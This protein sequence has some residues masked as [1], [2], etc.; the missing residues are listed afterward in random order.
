[1]ATVFR[2]IWGKEA[3]IPQTATKGSLYITTDTGKIFLDT[4]DDISGRIDLN[5]QNI[6]DI[7]I[8]D[9]VLV[10]KKGDA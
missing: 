8:E 6:C 10:V 5:P 1:M 2:P 7:T 3:A 4:T 9:D